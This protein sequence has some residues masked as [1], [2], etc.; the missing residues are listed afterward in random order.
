MTNEDLRWQYFFIVQDAQSKDQP[1][2]IIRRREV[3]DGPAIEQLLQRGARWEDT[4]ILAIN[5]LGMYERE[6]V[7]AST[8]KALEYLVR[9]YGATEPQDE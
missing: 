7:P 1:L 3:P 9:R 8:E 5:S 4:G 2:G 6:I